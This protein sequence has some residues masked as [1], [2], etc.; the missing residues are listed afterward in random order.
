MGKVRILTRDETDNPVGGV[1]VEIKKSGAVIVSATTNDRGEAT[2]DNV[3]PGTYEITTS[4]ES[5]E[6]LAQADL[7][8][9]V[10]SP[11]DVVFIMVPKVVLKDSVEVK[12]SASQEVEKVASAPTELQ[13]TSVKDLANKPATVTDTLPLVPG[14]VRSPEGEIKISGSGEHRSALVVN[15]A[16]VTDPATGQ[17]GV[18]VPVDSVETIN[19]FKTPYLAQYG[20]FTAGVVSVETRRGGDKWNFELNDPLPEFRIKSGQ[21][22]GIRE[23]SPRI[24]FNGP[25]I[26][27]KLFFSQGNEYDLQKLPDRTLPFP[28]NETKKESFNSFSQFDYII[29]PLHTLTGTLHIAPSHTSFVNLNF[30]NQQEVTPNFAARDYTGT[31]IDRLTI[32]ENLLEST[33]AIKRFGLNIWGQGDEDMI[34]RPTGNSGNYFS[35]QDRRAT[36]VEWIETFSLAPIKNIGEHNLKFGTSVTRTHNSGDFIARTTLIQGNQGEP[37]K[38]IDFLGGGPF[39]LTDLETSVFGQDHWVINPKLAMDIGARFER[40]GITGTFRLAPRVGLAWTPFA[41]Q[42]TTVRGGFGLFYDRV[43]LNVYAFER[44]PRMVITTFGSD[45]EIIDG[46]RLFANITDR[47]ESSGSPFLFS[48]DKIGNFAPYSATWNV[49]VEHPLTKNIRVRANW[50]QSNSQGIIVIQPKVIKDQDALVLG[51]N[52][53]SRYRQLEL[54]SRFTLS[55]G[56]QLFFSYVRSR[57]RGDLNEFNTYLG[58]FPFPVVRP[59]EYTNLSSDLPNRFLAWGSVRLPWQMRVAPLVEW[60]NGFPYATTDVAQN[61]VGL[62]NTNRYP[63]FF[64][65]DSRVSKDF[66]INDKYSVRFSVSGFNLTNH[67][68]PLHL[69]SN[70]DDPRYGVF[71]GGHSRRFRL[72]FD[73]LF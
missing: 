42:Q 11:V 49:E 58:N 34:L 1:V 32:G 36:R 55:D 67:F 6:P 10:G 54:T 29:S 50:L 25:L 43:P 69:H 47:A 7:A 44:Y 45:G 2:L 3:P 13:R 26:P 19:V 59:N 64:S 65:F 28:F 39:K 8:V 51:G 18:T 66:K 16:D 37:V 61:Y 20:R 27:G 56:Q 38:Q 41:N 72:D 53:R 33:L 35:Q 71:F 5:F 30:F 17:F 15:A 14:V 31:V 57:A 52:G 12:A 48:R 40:Q 63:S 62:P 21:L 68:N 4:K 46:P 73:V 23:A 22:K 9:S 60:R 70:I 24:V